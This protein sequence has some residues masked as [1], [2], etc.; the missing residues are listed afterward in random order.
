MAA[1]GETFAVGQARD[2]GGRIHA[3]NHTSGEVC[4]T[5]SLSNRK[6]EVIAARATAFLFHG[7][8]NC[9]TTP[10]HSLS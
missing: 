2:T 1:R 7:N 3:S 9:R 4:Q 5:W 10:A 6:A 8:T